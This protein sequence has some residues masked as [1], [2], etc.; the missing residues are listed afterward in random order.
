MAFRF[1]RL[2]ASQFADWDAFVETCSVGTI[3]HTTR[4]LGC[5]PG[6]LAVHVART[7]DGEIVAGLPLLTLRRRIRGYLPPQF[8]PYYGIVYADKY[9]QEPMRHFR[10]YA[11][12]VLGLLRNTRPWASFDLHF[13]PLTKNFQ[14]FIWA[15]FSLSVGYTFELPGDS[16]AFEAG[17]WSDRRANLRRARA[18]LQTGELIVSSEESEGEIVRLVANTAAERNFRLDER[19]LKTIV[20]SMRDRSR[21]LIARTR[22]GHPIQGILFVFDSRRGYLLASGTAGDNAHRLWNPK[23][24]LIL[25]LVEFCAQKNLVFDFEG[26]IIPRIADYNRRFG[27]AMRPCVRGQKLRN[28]LHFALRSVYQYAVGERRALPRHPGH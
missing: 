25:N 27:A 12:V 6:T 23:T 8:T 3:F 18:E 14:P 9:D 17:L 15:G 21:V 19:V 22:D 28:P 26:S 5:M 13:H 1:E 16:G 24:L 4:W 2:S 10:E 7:A 11:E 20:H